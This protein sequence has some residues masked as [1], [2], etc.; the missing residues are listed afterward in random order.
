MKYFKN[1]MKEDKLKVDCESQVLE[2][3][4]KYIRHR[5]A[6][7]FDKTNEER[8]KEAE[9][10][11]RQGLEPLPDP[12]EEE[13]KAKEDQFNAL[14]DAGKIQWAKDE[15]VNQLRK[16]ADERMRIKG[17]RSTDKRELFKTIRYAFISH[18]ELLKCSRDPIFDE[19]KEYLVEGLTYKIDPEEVFGKEDTIIS[20]KPRQHYLVEDEFD[21]LKI[22][23]PQYH[24]LDDSTYPGQ[25]ES[26]RDYD[27]RVNQNKFPNYKSKTASNQAKSRTLASRDNK[28]DYINNR[29]ADF[30]KNWL[31]SPKKPLGTTIADNTFQRRTQFG[32]TNI[33]VA[34]PPKFG[35]GQNK[36]SK[37]GPQTFKTVRT[38]AV[39]SFDYSFDLDENGVFYYL[40]TEGGR[41][42]W[43]NPHTIGQVQ[44]FASSIGFGSVH[45]LVGRK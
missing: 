24:K 10:R 34:P 15:E 13:K 3:V 1:L 28:A 14:D 20:L 30:E 2:L 18:A 5:A 22:K 17:L 26:K 37:I 12:E 36:S 44:A 23:R 43:Q 42:I 9:D 8:Q 39:T 25:E 33:G 6:I 4:E 31:G 40:G 41:K 7:P 16:A 45:E 38:P 21:R 32:D 19:A 11:Q 29:A 35:L 27:G